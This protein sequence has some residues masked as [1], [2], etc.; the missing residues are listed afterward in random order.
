MYKDLQ[1]PVAMVTS[2][3]RSVM[4]KCQYHYT[5]THFTA[6]KKTF[7]DFVQVVDFARRH[8]YITSGFVTGAVVAITF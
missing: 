2:W 6:K 5:K 1:V 8:V 4:S 3:S 7:Y